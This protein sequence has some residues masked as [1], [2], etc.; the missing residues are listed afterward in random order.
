M[1]E[2]MAFILDGDDNLSPVFRRIG[3]SA[4]RFHRRLNESVDESGG[5]LR[6]FTRGASGQLQEL[7]GRLDTAGQAA[8]ALGVRT[9]GAS[10]GVRALGDDAARAST[11]ID[12]LTR[13]SGGRLR[14]LN[15]RFVAAGRSARSFT[16]DVDRASPSVNRLGNAAG[17]TAAQLGSGGGGLGASMGV[18]AGIA[19]V[20]LLPALGALV[21]MLAGVG[22]AA[23]TMKLGFSGVGEAVEAAGKGKKEY[24]AALKALPAPAREF[25]KQLVATKKEFSGLSGEIQKVMLPG[26]TQALKESSPVIKIVGSAMTEM[27]KGF[28]DAAAGAGRLMKD[29]GFQKDFGTVLRLGNGF[30]KDLT[31]GLG[32]LARGF[33]RFGAASEPTL[34]TL[35][36]GISDLLG[37]GLPGMFQGLERG[38]DG[39]AKFLSGFFSMLNN[40]VLPGLGRFAGEVARTFGPFLGEQMKFF[41]RVATEALDA[42]GAGMRILSPVFKDL[43]FGFQAVLAVADY[44]G[45]V[46][47]N[48]GRAILDSLAPVGEG[49]RGVEGPLQ[50]LK[51]WVDQNKLGF[52]EFGRIASG[53][54]LGM[55]DMGLSALPH[56]MGAFRMLAIGALNSIDVMVTASAAMFGWIPGFGEKLREAQG[57]FDKFKGGF[58]AGLDNAQGKASDFVASIRPK[59]AENKLKLDITSYESQIAVAKE[60]LKTVPPEKKSKLTGHIE[61]LERKADAARRELAAVRDRHVGIYV[62]EYR[63]RTF[64]PNP[65]AGGQANAAGGLIRGPGTGTSDSIASWLSNGEYVIRASSVA[66]I[67]VGA[68]DALNEGRALPA[69]T[70]VTAAPVRA[71]AAASQAARQMVVNVTV[72]GAMDPIAVAQQMQR[73]LLKL[74]RD[75]GGGDGL[76]A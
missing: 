39:S 76:L 20:S 15:G 48:A 51:G 16:L 75:Y 36:G 46:F 43:T 67:G 28:G 5:Q 63:T 31:S 62:T 71:V 25:T 66:R 23:G 30:V 9:D 53:A 68:L 27:G 54:I 74:R 19:G 33:L 70:G 59:L 55:V 56:L 24:A 41:G 21:P 11:Q 34:R 1:A 40:D 3:E 7:G 12:R 6:T 35:S 4:E 22:L 49:L 57:D 73:M 60:E 47:K 29:S 8:R 2:R 26:F 61:D 69:G 44:V 32:G 42:L 10:T 64:T 14:D 72:Q 58:I 18:V 17:E 45:P 52:M 38:I 65:R 37:K 50:R 13:D